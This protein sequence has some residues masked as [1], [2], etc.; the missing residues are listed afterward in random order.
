VA[1]REMKF[2][3]Q[4]EVAPSTRGRRDVPTREERLPLT[5]K[6]SN[7]S[8]WHHK[9]R[10]SSLNYV[11]DIRFDPHML[12][13]YIAKHLPSVVA[14]GPSGRRCSVQRDSDDIE[15]LA[16]ES[17]LLGDDAKALVAAVSTCHYTLQTVAPS[18]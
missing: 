2:V 7:P 9:I 16:S 6:P 10:H 11:H 15:E 12:A 13:L 8:I 1:Y 14:K 3:G 18:S 5:N 17:H 4:L